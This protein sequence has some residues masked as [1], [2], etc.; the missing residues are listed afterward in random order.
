VGR[1]DGILKRRCGENCW[2]CEEEFWGDLVEFL[3]RCLGRFGG[4]LKM[5]PGEI[6]WNCEEYMWDDMVEV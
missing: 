3:R 4:I 2:N 1:F 5:M 6:W